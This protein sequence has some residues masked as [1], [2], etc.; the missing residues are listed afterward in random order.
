MPD[1]LVAQ[2]WCNRASVTSVLGADPELKR[3]KVNGL[4][5]LEAISLLLKGSAIGQVESNIAKDWIH[6][7]VDSRFVDAW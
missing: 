5:T 6:L 1:M 4:S 3:V 7:G 2:A